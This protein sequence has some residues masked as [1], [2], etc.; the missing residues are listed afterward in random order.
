MRSKRRTA[1]SLI[2]AASC[3]VAGVIVA[4]V[5][6][7]MLIIAPDPMP[8]ATT[9]RLDIS[10]SFWSVVE[11]LLGPLPASNLSDIVTII[12]VL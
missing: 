3:I 10:E 2:V 7:C 5:G 11:G 8:S 6:L 12:T 4:S 1:V 9:R